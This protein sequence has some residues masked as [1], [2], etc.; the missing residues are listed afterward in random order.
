MRRR[1]NK[2]VDCFEAVDHENRLPYFEDV[3]DMR[4]DISLD[5]TRAAEGVVRQI[6]GDPLA[7]RKIGVAADLAMDINGTEDLIFILN[8][9]EDWH[10]AVGKRLPKDDPDRE[11]L[12]EE[13]AAVPARQ[14][15]PPKRRNQFPLWY[16]MVGPDGTEEYGV[17]LVPVRGDFRRVFN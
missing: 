5:P 9:T 13:W 2:V 14:V 10:F 12:P 8:G 6:L 7:I 15:L 17:A 16:V 3:A 4:I 11:G 1:K